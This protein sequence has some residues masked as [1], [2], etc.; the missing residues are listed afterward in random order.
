MTDQEAYKIIEETITLLRGSHHWGMITI[1][2]NQGII[3][4]VNLTV[5][6]RPRPGSAEN[7]GIIKEKT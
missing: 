4:R 3:K 7:D 6:A 1:E 5:S 2:V